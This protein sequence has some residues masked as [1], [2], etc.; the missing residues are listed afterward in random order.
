MNE[1]EQLFKD[2]E[3]VS[4][5]ASEMFIELASLVGAVSDASDELKGNIPEG[6][7]KASLR[8]AGSLARY[9]QEELE[10]FVKALG[11]ELPDH[12]KEALEIVEKHFPSEQPEWEK[13]VSNENN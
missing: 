9:A 2:L 8:Y 12:W 1:G 3:A 10:P 13:E 7:L 11:K 5:A 4:K 6:F